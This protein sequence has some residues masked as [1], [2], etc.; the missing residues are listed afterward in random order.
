MTSF[1]SAL[2]SMKKL[3]AQVHPLADLSL[4]CHEVTSFVCRKAAFCGRPFRS[5]Q[6]RDRHAESRGNFSRK[7]KRQQISVVTQERH[8]GEC[9]L[10]SDR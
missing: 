9:N 4:N 8:S 2:V 6:Q 10:M 5:K 1:F 3:Q 7:F